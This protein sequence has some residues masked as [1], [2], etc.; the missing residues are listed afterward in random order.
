LLQAASKKLVELEQQQGL[1]ISGVDLTS[2]EIQ[3]GE[4]LLRE[5]LVDL[6]EGGPEA[7]DSLRSKLLDRK[8]PYIEAILS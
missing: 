8:H 3:N 5:F 4:V 1:G 7:L 6:K 2:E